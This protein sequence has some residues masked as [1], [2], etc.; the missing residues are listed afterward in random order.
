MS[1]IKDKIEVAL[2]M[3]EKNDLEDHKSKVDHKIDKASAQAEAA[4]DKAASYDK[5][6]ARHEG[7]MR[8]LDEGRDAEASRQYA[9]GRKDQFMQDH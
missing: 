7:R 2:G 3:K 1:G 5:E 4:K 6:A 9:A 8:G